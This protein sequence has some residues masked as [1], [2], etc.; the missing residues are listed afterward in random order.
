MK[1][2]GQ[3]VCDHKSAL[4]VVT[5]DEQFDGHATSSCSE[6]LLNALKQ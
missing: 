5:W 6:M 2:N 1:Q 4:V 3:T